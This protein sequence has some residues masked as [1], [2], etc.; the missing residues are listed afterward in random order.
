MILNF[1]L[2]QN[3]IN[4]LCYSYYM[5]TNDYSLCIQYII[6][7]SLIIIIYKT[8]TCNKLY[9]IYKTDSWGFR[10]KNQYISS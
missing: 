5:C 1:S 6:F 4:D 8:L 3:E 7:Y 10:N 9:I 2:P